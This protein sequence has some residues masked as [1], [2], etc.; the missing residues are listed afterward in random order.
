MAPYWG[1]LNALDALEADLKS[2]NNQNK[3][4]RLLVSEFLHGED[5]H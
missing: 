4:E 5:L 2:F 1:D 3:D